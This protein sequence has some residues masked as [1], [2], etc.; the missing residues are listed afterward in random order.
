MVVC[1]RMLTD[2]SHVCALDIFRFFLGGG[3]GEEYLQTE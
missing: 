1:I 3:G 2:P